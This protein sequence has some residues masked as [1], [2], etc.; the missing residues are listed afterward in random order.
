MADDS[1]RAAEL[2]QVMLDAQIK[3]TVAR[4]SM[5]A[6]SPSC[7]LCGEEIPAGRRAALPNACMCVDC[8]DRFDRST[9]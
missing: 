3:A 8:Q 1:D 7:L 5:A 4:L 2:E 9:R 6:P